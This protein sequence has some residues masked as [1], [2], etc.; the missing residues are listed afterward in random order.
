MHTEVDVFE[1]ESPTGGGDVAQATI[2]RRT[3]TEF[4]RV[5]SSGEPARRSRNR[6]GGYAVEQNRNPSSE[7]R[8]SD[9]DDVEILSGL[10]EGE[11]LV[12]S[13][14]SG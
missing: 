3:Q 6:V 13:D 9:R 1:S 14:R 11:M 12:V 2:H 5:R 4:D 8:H 7:P 10:E